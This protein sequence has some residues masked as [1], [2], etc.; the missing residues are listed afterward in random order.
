MIVEMAMPLS[1]NMATSV[2]LVP[3]RYVGRSEVRFHSGAPYGLF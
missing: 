1:R 3:F 2:T